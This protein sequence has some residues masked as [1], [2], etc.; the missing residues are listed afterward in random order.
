MELEQKVQ[1]RIKELK[2]KNKQLVEAER[3]AAIGKITNRV[4]HELRNPLT[5]VGGFARR[6]SQKTPADDPNKKYLQIILDEV[7]AM[8]SKVSEI[9]RIRSQ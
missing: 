9:T 7:I 8:E 3:L 6:I 4:A 5:V 1:E 2:Q